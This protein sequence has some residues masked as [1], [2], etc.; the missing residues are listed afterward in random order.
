MLHRKYFP[1]A[2]RRI[3]TWPKVLESAPCSRE[4]KSGGS[5]SCNRTA[6]GAIGQYANG[7]MS[8]TPQSASLSTWT[9][10][11]SRHS[12]SIPQWPSRLPAYPPLAP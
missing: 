5:A 3:A 2:G 8:A 7:E 10:K 12:S 1:V 11:R 6:A 4:L 9:A